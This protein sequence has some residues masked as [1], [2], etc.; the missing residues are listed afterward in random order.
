MPFEGKYI[1]TIYVSVREV[2]SSFTCMGRC[3]INVR[4]TEEKHTSS[5]L[6]CERIIL[7]ISHDYLY[8]TTFFQ[9]LIS[10]LLK[11]MRNNCDRLPSS[12]YNIEGFTSTE[13]ISDVVTAE[14]DFYK[15]YLVWFSCNVTNL[16]S[17]IVIKHKFYYWIRIFVFVIMMHS[18]C[19]WFHI[20]RNVIGLVW[21]RY[22]LYDFFWASSVSWLIALISILHLSVKGP[23]I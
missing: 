9:P 18:C 19:I 21:L 22:W 23:P 17:V 4:N 1:R 8:R 15:L 14:A 5:P 13:S 12:I 7:A 20:G 2:L 10:S 11:T 6:T 16:N 3:F